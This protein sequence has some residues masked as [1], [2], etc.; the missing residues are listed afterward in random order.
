MGERIL[1]TG[2]TGGIGVEVLNQLHAKKVCDSVTVLARK[3]AKNEKL[4]SDYPLKKIVWGDV[5]DLA[6]VKEACIDQDVVLHLAAVIPTRERDNRDY[7]FKINLGGTK[8]VIAAIEEKSPQALLVYTSSVTVYGD[9]IH[10]HEIRVSDP[11]G[12][13]EHDLYGQTK[14]EAESAIRASKCRFTTFRLSAIMGIGR[15]WK[16]GRRLARVYRTEES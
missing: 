4:L 16:V 7:I 10:A 1:I 8:N 14:I 15:Y 9:R 11:I 5:T 6:K 13:E 3:S 12:T 2:A